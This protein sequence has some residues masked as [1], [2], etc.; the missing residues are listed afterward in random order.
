MQN[1]IKSLIKLAKKHYGQQNYAKAL[2]CFKEAAELGDAIAQ[3]FT[4]MIYDEGKG[5]LQDFK[6]AVYW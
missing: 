1:K 4:V 6:Q 5:V 2:E 3:F